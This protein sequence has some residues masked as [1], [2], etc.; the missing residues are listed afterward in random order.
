MTEQN[1][2]LSSFRKNKTQRPASV[3]PI[4]SADEHRS[5][6]TDILNHSTRISSS[7]NLPKSIRIAKDTHV[8][9]TTLARLQDKP[10]YQEITD[11]LEDYIQRQPSSVRKLIRSSVEAS[12]E[13]RK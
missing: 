4:E 9:I 2:G 5:M 3:K 1:I 10:I 6:P 13:E 8:A 7:K 12:K 11:I